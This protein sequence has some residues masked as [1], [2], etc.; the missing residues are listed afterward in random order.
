MSREMSDRITV[1]EELRSAL[2][3]LTEEERLEVYADV[4]DYLGVNLL[5]KIRTEQILKRR[6]K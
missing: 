6:T 4:F 3:S 5:V 2:K 1:R